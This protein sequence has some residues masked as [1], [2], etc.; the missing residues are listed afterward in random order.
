MDAHLYGFAPCYVYK[1]GYIFTFTLHDNRIIL[2]ERHFT[3]YRKNS[4]TYQHNMHT[5]KDMKSK[6]KVKIV[7]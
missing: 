3:K 6:L 7:L 5:N 2:R 4:S 1:S